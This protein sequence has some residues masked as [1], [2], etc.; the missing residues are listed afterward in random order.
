MECR[1]IGFSS[2]N[3]ELSLCGNIVKLTKR[4]IAFDLTDQTAMNNFLNGLA[5]AISGEEP[6]FR[7]GRDINVR[8]LFRILTVAYYNET[9]ENWKS[10]FRNLAVMG[11]PT[12]KAAFS[13]YFGARY[14]RSKEEDNRLYDSIRDFALD[15]IS[16]QKHRDI[17]YAASDAFTV[18][19]ISVDNNVCEY[20]I[21]GEA[22][23]TICLSKRKE[24]CRAET[25]LATLN[26]IS[27]AAR[28]RDYTELLSII[29]NVG[30]K[31]F[32]SISEH[33]F[34]ADVTECVMAYAKHIVKSNRT[35]L[36]PRSIMEEFFGCGYYTDDSDY[37][38]NILGKLERQITEM[39]DYLIAHNDDEIY[40]DKTEWLIYEPSANR[41]L[42]CRIY[43][44]GPKQY[45]EEV[46][47][48]C[49]KVIITCRVSCQPF[50]YSVQRIARSANIAH[51]ALK[52]IGFEFYSTAELKT[53][54]IKALQAQLTEKDGYD[55][56]T[57]RE[58]LL[59]LKAIHI[60]AA[61]CH[62]KL[63][64]QGLCCRNNP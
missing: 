34:R 40:S 10:Y 9:I 52:A 19:R 22:V 56:A 47:E 36:F 21:N 28:K 27:S 62:T 63:V 51:R 24:F 8:N 30:K 57:Q 38:A 18:E 35:M 7:C 4:N 39:D 6:L 50:S 54:H 29:R 16:T 20:K 61:S 55:V 26:A 5:L 37:F 42:K 25:M 43:F 31:A 14:I 53:Y 59:N 1:I 45:V 2:T 33:L 3:V 32:L 41:A 13:A 46:Q 44:D 15:Y 11:Q 64:T 17:A 49:R 48:Y 58:V 60:N 23:I 12:F